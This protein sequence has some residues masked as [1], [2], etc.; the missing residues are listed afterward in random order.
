MK[1][2]SEIFT[3]PKSGNNDIYTYQPDG[4]KRTIDAVVSVNQRRENISSI[5]KDQNDTR[6]FMCAVRTLHS[7][8]LSEQFSGVESN[9]SLAPINTIYKIAEDMPLLTGLG[10][11]F[12]QKLRSD[13]RSKNPPIDYP[14]NLLDE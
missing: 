6:N 11:K 14:K 12:Y 1:I 5:S 8:V 13:A 2:S 10:E 4:Q 3:E 7:N 9:A